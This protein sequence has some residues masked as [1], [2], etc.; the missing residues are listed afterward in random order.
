METQKNLNKQCN[1]E[2]GN[3]AV[4]IRLLDFRLH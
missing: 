1:A 4:G 2:K 3:G